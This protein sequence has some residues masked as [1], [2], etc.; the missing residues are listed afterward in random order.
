MSQ[1]RIL[2]DEAF[3]TRL[4]DIEEAGSVTEL[5]AWCKDM[6][7]QYPSFSLAV[8]VVDLALRWNEENILDANGVRSIMET[9]LTACGMDIIGSIS[10]WQKY[11]DF[12]IDEHEELIEQS[13]DI[14]SS[15]S[16][17]KSKE[18][19][20]KVI[21]R[22]LALPL[23]GNEET[24]QQLNTVLEEYCTESD[25]TI[26]KPDQL[27]RK[28]QSA[29]AFREERL[30]FEIFLHGEQYAQ[31][32]AADK[33]KAWMTYIDFEISAK[34][35][36]RAQRLY[37]RALLEPVCASEA[38]TLWLKYAFF[39]LCT[40]KQF[41]VAEIVLQRALVYH[42]TSLWLRK[43]YYL[44]VEGSWHASS[45]EGN[46]DIANGVLDKVQKLLLESVSWGYS[47]AYSYLSAFVAHSNC[48]RRLF[49]RLSRC[50][51]SET[52]QQEMLS[53]LQT[54]LHEVQHL[55]LQY[56]GTWVEGAAMIC[57]L[58]VFI[59]TQVASS[60]KYVN[61][62]AV[63][64]SVTGKGKGSLI[65]KL[66]DVWDPV[67]QVH[68]HQF[69]LWRDT[70]AS[71]STHEILFPPHEKW[72]L[73]ATSIF[74]RIWNEVQGARQHSWL[75]IDSPLT[76]AQEWLTYE[77]Q[78]GGSWQGLESGE[79]MF[80]INSLL[81]CIERVK[82]AIIQSCELPIVTVSES[83]ADTAAQPVQQSQQL[84]RPRGSGSEISKKK[85]EDSNQMQIPEVNEHDDDDT[86]D[87]DDKQAR[88]KRRG[89]G[90]TFQEHQQSQKQSQPSVSEPSRTESPAHEKDT[91]MH[92]DDN[93]ED[94]TAAVTN[95]KTEEVMSEAD[96]LRLKHTVFVG[97]LPL[98]VDDD[99]LRRFFS[100][101]GALQEVRVARDR[102]SG[103]SKGNA[104]V[105]FAD[106][107]GVAKALLQNKQS[108][109]E[110]G[111]RISVGPSKFIIQPL[112]KINPYE[113]RKYKHYPHISSN[114][115][116][117]QQ[118]VNETSESTAPSAQ[119]E[120]KSKPPIITATTVTSFRPRGVHMKAK[121]H[122]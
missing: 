38:V 111:A 108:I 53:R 99:A 67:T 66:L 11:F 93:H 54:A 31:A 72:Q 26:I 32:T 121:L 57:K 78:Y 65:Q 55:F 43:L 71:F 110:N 9:V 104:L 12:E 15:E 86:E 28:V 75:D 60:R 69:W 2:T 39:A 62:S 73:R 17:K 30:T 91:H 7:E 102:R 96:T 58:H 47:D 115:H 27:Q 98:D 36:T 48:L 45:E 61:A 107:T 6:T 103:V 14:L 19:F 52:Q 56:F 118:V 51:A 70:I 24:L 122:L 82:E 120:V 112:P 80:L 3:K 59:L 18:R 113:S 42:P 21:E 109:T 119:T 74:K 76:L 8:M 101:C 117:S 41:G 83:V 46:I 23:A 5:Q 4:L 114:Q 81:E 13:G 84:K 16:L 49:L 100:S 68:S 34:Q 35:Y 97:R 90:V 37:E 20:I 95:N 50:S 63:V 10:L 29:I 116:Q 94:N 87:F 64:D 88:K 22:Q 79:D 1:K 44:A 89:L 33:L 105:E 25:I 85:E 40:I 77:D 106:E 92:V